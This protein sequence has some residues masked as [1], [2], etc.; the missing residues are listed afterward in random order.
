MSSWITRSSSLQACKD[1]CQGSGWFLCESVSSG[2]TGSV[3]WWRCP[4]LS[5]L[6]DGFLVFL[7]VDEKEVLRSGVD[8]EDTEESDPVT[9]YLFLLS[10]FL[11]RTGILPP[12]LLEGSSPGLAIDELSEL[13]GGLGAFRLISASWDADFDALTGIALFLFVFDSRE[14]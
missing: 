12:F 10:D 13:T 5:F 6:G 9:P 2:M 8:G 7:T 1:G 3:L 11:M 4:R 14:G